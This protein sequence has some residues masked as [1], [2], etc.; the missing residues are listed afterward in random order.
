M[1]YW[2]VYSVRQTTCFYMSA[3]R[4]GLG[5]SHNDLTAND[6]P[7]QITGTAD[8]RRAHYRCSAASGR[9][10]CRRRQDDR[11]AFAAAPAF[12]RMVQMKHT[13]FSYAGSSFEI[14]EW[15]GS[16]PATLNVHHSDDEAW[17]VFEGELT[18]RYADHTQIVA[19]GQT[20]FVP[21]R[22]GTY[23]T[24]GPETRYLIV[25][26]PR[27]RA[28]IEELQNNPDPAVQPRSIGASIQN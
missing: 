11:N 12:T 1:A 19:T 13:P 23:Y 28:L 27:L 6:Y 26:P 21:R 24:A 14:H 7:F 15:R 9:L 8:I 10:Y 3:G 4:V 25:L 5:I 22:C 16:G 2:Q 20:V 17:H 18:F